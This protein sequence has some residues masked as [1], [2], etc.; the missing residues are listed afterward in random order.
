MADPAVK[1]VG[2]LLGLRLAA[3][4]QDFVEAGLADNDIALCP[5]H[6]IV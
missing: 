4:A 6:A 3:V 5:A 1:A 2:C